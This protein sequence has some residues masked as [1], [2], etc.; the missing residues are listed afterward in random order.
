MNR[1]MVVSEKNKPLT[2]LALASKLIILSFI[3]R[4]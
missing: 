3:V 1:L 4:N 2:R